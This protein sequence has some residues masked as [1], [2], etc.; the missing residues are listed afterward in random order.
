M[1]L[2]GKT[3]F[4]KL[5]TGLIAAILFLCVLLAFRQ[6]LVA[7]LWCVVCACLGWLWFRWLSEELVISCLKRYGGQCTAVTLARELQHDHI[8]A[9]VFR[10]EQKGIV[11]IREHDVVLRDPHHPCAFD[12]HR[13][14]RE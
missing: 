13:R 12:P 1:G 5:N 2:F 8:R 4:E 11:Q 6:F 10:L 14:S 3:A 9:P 7:G